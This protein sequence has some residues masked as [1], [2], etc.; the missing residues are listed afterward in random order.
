MVKNAAR[1]SADGRSLPG[2]LGGDRLIIPV[3]WK[4]GIPNSVTGLHQRTWLVGIVAD[5]VGRKL[6]RIEERIHVVES[7]ADD[8][9]IG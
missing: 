9:A 4:T 8:A 2:T 7:G 1:R 3:D 5:S 6:L